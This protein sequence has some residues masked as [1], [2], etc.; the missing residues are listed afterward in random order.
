MHFHLRRIYLDVFTETNVVTSAGDSS[1]DGQLAVECRST[2]H[3]IFGTLHREFSE[4]LLGMVLTVKWQ[5]TVYFIVST[6]K[7]TYGLALLSNSYYPLL[8][9]L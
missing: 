5:C 3:I 9:L 7:T 4:L 1:K 2:V 6:C 8:H